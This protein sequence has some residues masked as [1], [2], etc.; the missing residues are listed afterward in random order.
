LKSWKEA[1]E[2]CQFSEGGTLASIH[3]QEQL[4]F[5]YS[6]SREIYF[7]TGLSAIDADSKFGWTDGSDLVFT[8]WGKGQPDSSTGSN[9]CVQVSSFY[10]WQDMN[11]NL[12][13]PFICQIPFTL[14]MQRETKQCAPGWEQFCQSNGNCACYIYVKTAMSWLDAADYCK[15]NHSFLPSI[16]SLEEGSFLENLTENHAKLPWIGLKL[17]DGNFVW[18]DGTNVD[19][20]QWGS[21]EPNNVNSIEHCTQMRTKAYFQKFKPD[22]I[23]ESK[24]WN[25]CSCENYKE[26][27]FCKTKL[28]QSI[29][30][31]NFTQV[32]CPQG[33]TRFCSLG[34]FCNCYLF[35]ATQQTWEEANSVCV[36]QHQ[37]HLTSVDSDAENTMLAYLL[38]GLNVPLAKTFG[39]Y[40]HKIPI[41]ANLKIQAWIGL[42]G[43]QWS[44][45][46]PPKYENWM[47]GIFFIYLQ[48]CKFSLALDYKFLI[49][50]IR[51]C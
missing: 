4:D 42:K 34:M 44:D 47:S 25:D 7:W 31:C 27:F 8:R 33:W 26:T 10:N 43:H 22:E 11:C 12:K 28:P 30:E 38:Q 46:S 24:K 41:N 49:S 16:H 51:F 39:Y 48:L 19:F 9:T 17:K 35:N 20:V 29:P 13:S 36:N 21:G 45:D 1:L 37:S 18:E 15:S 2:H 14:N 32:K 50:L 5:L 40:S 3:S 23:S 6:H